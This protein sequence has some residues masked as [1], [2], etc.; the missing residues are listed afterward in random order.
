MIPIFNVVCAEETDAAVIKQ[1]LGLQ[2]NDV[3]PP[4]QL[5][6]GLIRCTDFYMSKVDTKQFLIDGQALTQN[7]INNF[8]VVSPQFQIVYPEGNVFNQAPTD[9]RQ[10]AV[11]QGYWVL[12]KGLEPGEHTIEVVSGL[13][14]FSFLTDV[15]YH[16][17]IENTH[18]SS[19]LD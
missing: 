13:S 8:A 18:T 16:L 3:I 9:V 12:V 5:K 14:E 19:M 15:T 4:S 10:K 2:P 17:T 11:A 6:E 7:D 1:E